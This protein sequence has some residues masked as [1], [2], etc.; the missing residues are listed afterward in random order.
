LPIIFGKVEG[1]RILGSFLQLTM[2]LAG[3]LE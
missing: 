3:E 1:F 2:G